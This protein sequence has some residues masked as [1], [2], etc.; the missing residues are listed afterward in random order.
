MQSFDVVVVSPGHGFGLF[1]P[2]TF[3]PSIFTKFVL[4]GLPVTLCCTPGSPR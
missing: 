3:G 2:P 1:V 4:N